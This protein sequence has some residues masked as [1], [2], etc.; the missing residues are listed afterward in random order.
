MESSTP[1][2]PAI[3]HKELLPQPLQYCLSE[4][5]TRILQREPSFD[6][7]R[8]RSHQIYFVK[9]FAQRNG[10]QDLS[11]SQL[12][13]AFRCDAD[14]VKTALENSLN[15]LKVRGRHFAFDDESEI[16]ILEWIQIQAEKCAPVTRTDFR[17]HCK[18]KYSC[19]I[20]RRW[21]DSFILPHK[22]DLSD[23]KS[24]LQEDARLEVLRAFLDDTVNSIRESV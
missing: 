16:Q 10:G 2:A 4:R 23:T 15:D 18:V 14:R 24:T 12:S 13:K 7:L 20:S 1:A 19:S 9:D 5:M 17:H 3:P 8:F 11:L 21:V 22:A 6:Q